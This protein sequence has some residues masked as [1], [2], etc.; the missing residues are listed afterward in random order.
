MPTEETANH[1]E[2]TLAGFIGYLRR[3][4]MSDRTINAYTSDVRGFLNRSDSHGHS[5]EL[6]S[7]VAVQTKDLEDYIYGLARSGLKF[8][9]VRRVSCAL[10][11]FFLF[12]LDQGVIHKNPVATLSVKPV[13]QEVLS[14]EQIVSIFQYLTRRQL[15]AEESDLLRY[16]RDELILLLMIFYGVPQYQLSTLRLSSIH[17]IKKSVSLIISTRTSF[18]LHLS[19]LRKLRTYLELRKSTSDT[20]FLES[21]GDRPIH[22]MSIRHV[23]NEL[24]FALKIECTPKSLQHTYAFL[25]Q[26]PEIRESLIKRILS[27]G[28]THNYGAVPNA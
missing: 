10:K 4:K 5:T 6:N 13:R 20:I 22:K 26:H 19:V 23:L 15:S 7:I 16:R 17:T 1:I 27:N 28:F 8:A 11:S 18:Q 3:K 25:Q 9:S 21:F 12:L 2:T 24:S 14:A